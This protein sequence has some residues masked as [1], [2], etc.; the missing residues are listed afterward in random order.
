MI[1][2]FVFYEITFFFQPNLLNL[3]GIKNLFQYFFLYP[4]KT[5]SHLKC[6]YTYAYLY[7]ETFMVGEGEGEV[8]Y[9]ISILFQRFIFK[10]FNIS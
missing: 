10:T 1:R 4:C 5:L 3:R 9:K 6:E 2:D 7:I 8:Y